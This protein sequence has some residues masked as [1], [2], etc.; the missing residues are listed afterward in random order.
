M[1][2]FRHSSTNGMSSCFDKIRSTIETNINASQQQVGDMFGFSVITRDSSQKFNANLFMVE[3]LGDTTSSGGGAN[4]FKV[5]ALA[6]LNDITPQGFSDSWNNFIIPNT[7]TS[8][9]D[10]S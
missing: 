10:I 8:T 7:N 4:D 6:Q 5:K 3:R 2:S 1:K 9:W